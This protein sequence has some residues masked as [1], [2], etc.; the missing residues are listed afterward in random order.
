MML[1]TQGFDDAILIT[2]SIVI[3]LYRKIHRQP[4][5]QCLIAKHLIIFGTA[6][7]AIVGRLDG[8]VFANEYFCG[9]MLTVKRVKITSTLF[10]LQHTCYFII[11]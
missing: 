7:V 4:F 10:Q 1:P 2:N 11:L 5:A 6:L 8:K 3:K 9:N